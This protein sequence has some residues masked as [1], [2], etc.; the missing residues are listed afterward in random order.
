ML[1]YGHSHSHSVP[2]VHFT[3]S[4]RKAFV[5]ATVFRLT[6][7]CSSASQIQHRLKNCHVQRRQVANVKNSGYT[8]SVPGLKS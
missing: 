8:V 1:Q 6:V 4:S 5:N 7:V 2:C 3:L